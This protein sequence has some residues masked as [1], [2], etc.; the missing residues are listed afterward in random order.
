[1]EEMAINAGQAFQPYRSTQSSIE[2]GLSP[3]KALE[4]ATATI[5]FPRVPQHAWP[6]VRPDNILGQQFH[7]TQI[8]FDVQINAETGMSLTYQIMIYFEK[9]LKDYVSAKIAQLTVERLALM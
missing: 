9:P 3:A 4:L 2:V 6:Y 8:P 7:L 5:A 1:M